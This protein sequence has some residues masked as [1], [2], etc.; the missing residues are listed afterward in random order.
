MRDFLLDLLGDAIAIGAAAVQIGL[1]V[2]AMAAL[3]AVVFFGTLR[4][5]G[6]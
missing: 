1:W 6:A 4:L 3:G 2:V 5:L